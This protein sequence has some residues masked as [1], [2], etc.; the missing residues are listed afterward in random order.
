MRPNRIT[1]TSSNS[2]YLFPVDWLGGPVGLFATP[3]A[4]STY[5]IDYALFRPE[6]GDF[7]E[8]DNWV[9]ITAMTAA[10]DSQSVEV[11]PLTCIRITLDAG[12]EVEVDVVQ[13]RP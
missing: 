7:T 9:P 5:T 12:T 10:T 8:V 1:V 13:N 4:L 2:P 6:S 3:A 11:G